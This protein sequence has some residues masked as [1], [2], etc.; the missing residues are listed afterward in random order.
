MMIRV[1]RHAV[2]R[3]SASSKYK[4]LPAA[5]V[6]LLASAS[7]CGPPPQK[8]REGFLCRL[9]GTNTVAAAPGS[10]CGTDPDV[11]R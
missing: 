6:P 3:G 8:G 7:V 1:M 10:E 11:P 2:C 5:F 4:H 9:S